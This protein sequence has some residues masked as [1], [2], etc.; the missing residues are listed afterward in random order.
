MSGD[1]VDQPDNKAVMG[2]P[3]SVFHLILEKVRLFYVDARWLF[4]VAAIILLAASVF[5]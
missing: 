4:D 3:G 5:Y 2:I 1:K